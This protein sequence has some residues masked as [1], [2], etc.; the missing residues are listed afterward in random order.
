MNTVETKEVITTCDK[1]GKDY[2]KETIRLSGALL[3]TP[4][5]C[6][7]CII[8]DDEADSAQRNEDS[9]RSLWDRVVPLAYRE[10]DINHTDFPTSVNGV[11]Q[12][13]VRG[14]GVPN[15]D[16]LLMLGLIGESGIGK[17]RVVSQVV[18]RIIWDNHGFPH[19]GN[20]LTWANSSQ[21]QWACQNQFNDSEKYKASEFLK[22]C[23]NANYLVM[24][25]IGSLKSTEVI[26]DN[27]YSLIEHR[28]TNNL[29]MIWT[30]NEYLEEMMPRLGEK[31][32]K[33]ITSRLAGFSNIINF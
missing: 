16:K 3:L 21:Y 18:K 8:E 24:D 33:R 1:C 5:K 7:F 29:P 25:D 32:R 9:S 26:S 22:K 20:A 11:C 6:E 31:P 4:D 12:D 14:D 13:W 17:T 2:L 30:S 28:T 27:L 15:Q 19:T 23:R 10:T